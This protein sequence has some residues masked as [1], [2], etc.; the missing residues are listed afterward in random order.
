M[1]TN[2]TFKPFVVYSVVALFYFA[3]C[4]PIS[5]WSKRLEGRMALSGR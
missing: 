5:V 2:A 1:I 4:Y 3:L